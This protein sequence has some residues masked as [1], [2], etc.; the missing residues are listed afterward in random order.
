MLSPVFWLSLV[1]VFLGM[2]W[3]AEGFLSLGRIEV[4]RR[5][6][7]APVVGAPIPWRDA[8]LKEAA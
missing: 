3:L 8:A 7:V 6:P 5:Q 1:A 2:K 4:R